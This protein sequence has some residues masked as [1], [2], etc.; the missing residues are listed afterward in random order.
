MIFL[1]LD[2]EALT[3]RNSGSTDPPGEMVSSVS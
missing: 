2:F 1:L 3:R